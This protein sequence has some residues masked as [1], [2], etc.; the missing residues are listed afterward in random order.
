MVL[1]PPDAP[2]TDGTI[3]LRLREPKDQ[4]RI[5]A[6]SHDP[7]SLRWLDDEP[8]PL[9]GT[10]AF[11]DPRETWSGGERAPFVIADPATDHALGLLSLRVVSEGTG[12][13][14]V[15]VFPE[16]R[17]RGVAPAALRLAARW[18]I[19]E[20]GFHRI[21]AEAD[22]ANTASLR[23]I[24]KA[25]FVREGILRD[26]CESHGRR[27]DCVMFAFVPAGLRHRAGG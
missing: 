8:I 20:C 27:H 5:A 23:A 13:L 25:G 16:G 6:A 19:G 26:H 9:T 1:T 24:E 18:A 3:V 4:E 21:E 15:S 10:P 14:A 7:E 22:V 17:G 2:L 12:S 11:R